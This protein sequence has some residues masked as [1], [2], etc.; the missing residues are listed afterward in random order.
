LRICQFW[1]IIQDNDKSQYRLIYI[2]KFE[3]AIYVFHGITKKTS[4]STSDRDITLAKK[5]LGEINQHR[6]TSEKK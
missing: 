2:A 3:E 5:R 6:Q 1:H 4:E